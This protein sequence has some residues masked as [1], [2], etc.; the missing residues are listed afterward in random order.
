MADA[1]N[2]VCFHTSAF[3][4]S[5][6]KADYINEHNFGDDLAAALMKVLKAKG[7]Q[8]DEIGQEDFGW[9]FCFGRDKPDHTFLVGHVSDTPDEWVAWV[10]RNAGLLGSIF[11][12]RQKGIQPEALQAVH[13]ALIELPAQDIQ[14]SARVS[15]ESFPEPI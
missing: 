1:R 11:G 15:K 10:E 9:Y 8:V 6:T 5:Q 4:T 13:Q 2:E 3:N 14:W 7:W 12:G